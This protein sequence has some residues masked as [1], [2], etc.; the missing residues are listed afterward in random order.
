[1]NDTIYQIAVLDVQIVTETSGIKLSQFIICLPHAREKASSYLLICKIALPSTIFEQ[2]RDHAATLCFAIQNKIQ[3][4]SGDAEAI[5]FERAHRSGPRLYPTRP[6][7]IVAKFSSQK[8]REAVR[9]LS[10]NL[11][12]TVFYVHE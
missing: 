4:P 11:K 8:Q 2:N 7:K 9:A 6:L 1:M 5:K 3:M 12:G 10:K